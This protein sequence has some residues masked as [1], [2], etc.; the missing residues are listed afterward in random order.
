MSI[1]LIGQSTMKRMLQGAAALLEKNA[2][3]LTEIDSRTGD[4]DHGVTML[5]IAKLIQERTSG[6]EGGVGIHDF[7]EGLGAA[8][9]EIKGGSAGPLYGTLIGGLGAQVRPEEAELDA[10]GA[11]R[12][13]SGCLA[14]M[15]DVTPAKVGDKTMMD[16]LIPAAEAGQAA[17]GDPR[18]VWQAAARAAEEGAKATENYAAKFGRAK[19]Y[20][21]RTIGTPDAGALSTSLFLRG[22][23][24]G[25]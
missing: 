3:Y 16:A 22:M 11:K 8:V 15:R 21:E 24:D 9:M 10:E 2:D 14:E 4:G 20:K 1:A 18:A 5:K 23:A 25:V 19:N 6:W 12:M 13:L 7:L 17:E